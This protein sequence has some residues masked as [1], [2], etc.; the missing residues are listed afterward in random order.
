MVGR[1][2]TLTMYKQRSAVYVQLIKRKLTNK[3]KKERLRETERESEK[4]YVK[5]TEKQK[6]TSMCRRYSLSV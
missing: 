4:E 3:S 1:D 6:Q 5:G 2:V